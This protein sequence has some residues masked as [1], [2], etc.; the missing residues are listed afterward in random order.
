M[1][2]TRD[3]G[4]NQKAVADA[5]AEQRRRV[6]A[7]DDLGVNVKDAASKARVSVQLIRSIQNLLYTRISKKPRLVKLSSIH[8]S[9]TASND[10]VVDCFCS[11]GII[12]VCIG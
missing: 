3:Y 8:T 2:E 12:L 9:A 7:I 11:I 1:H 5:L 10:N 6:G 4:S